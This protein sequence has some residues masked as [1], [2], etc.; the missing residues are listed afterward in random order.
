MLLSTLGL[1]A[2]LLSKTVRAQGDSV[3]E[4]PVDIPAE[5]P[6]PDETTTALPEESK[7]A[8]DNDSSNAKGPVTERVAT[9]HVT[10]DV[11]GKLRPT[12][13]FEVPTAGALLLLTMVVTSVRLLCLSDASAN[14]M[15]IWEEG[16]GMHVEITDMKNFDDVE[17]KGYR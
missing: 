15:F 3:M 12:H 5:P 17:L 2:M 8:K 6:L 4:M 14:F 9:A 10:G 13:M 7:K 16:K 11:D 1:A